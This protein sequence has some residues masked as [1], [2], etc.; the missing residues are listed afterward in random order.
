MER[1]NGTYGGWTME[2]RGGGGGGWGELSKLKTKD[3]RDLKSKE[4]M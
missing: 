1:N 3:M 4:D 2:Y